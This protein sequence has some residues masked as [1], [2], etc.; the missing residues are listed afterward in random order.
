MPGAMMP[1]QVKMAPQ[2]QPVQRGSPMTVPA[3]TRIAP[4]PKPSPIVPART[5]G[6]PASIRG[7]PSRGS[8]I[9]RGARGGGMPPAR[10]RGVVQPPG[11]GAPI[12]TRGAM[13]GSPVATR[14]V[15][16]MPTPTRGG[17]VRGRGASPMAMASSRGR[18]AAAGLGVRG[19][20]VQPRGRG[21]GVPTSA[22]QM[23]QSRGGLSARG[24]IQAAVRGRGMA[25]APRGAISITH[26]R[27][28]APPP[29]RPPPLRAMPGPGPRHA[30]PQQV[31][32]LKHHKNRI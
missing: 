27:D 5:R 9:P 32:V 15:R 11:R 16:G 26:M 3:P 29:P 2:Q 19:G 24:S 4:G 14:G 8:P 10:G 30:G 13:R 20:G 31:K 23:M 6:S 25:S 28:G 22:A 12:A 7:S 18:G 17:M 1:G 21:G